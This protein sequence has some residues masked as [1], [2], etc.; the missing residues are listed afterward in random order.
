MDKLKDPERKT[1]E[2]DI[3]EEMDVTLDQ[4]MAGTQIE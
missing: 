3:E 4:D 2:H 1:Q